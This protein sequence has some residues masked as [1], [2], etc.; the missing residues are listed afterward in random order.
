MR[1]LLLAVLILLTGSPLAHAAEGPL[2]T[3][4]WD[5]N[6]NGVRDEGEPGYRKA[7]IAIRHDSG[8]SA[9]VTAN[10]DGT[11]VLP[12]TGKWKISH[13]ET[14]YVTTTPTSV[15]SDGDD[16]EFGVRGAEVCGTV[17]RDI[18]LDAKI[19]E[20]EPG[21]EG[22]R[23]SVVGDPDHSTTTAADGTYCLHDLPT[24]TSRFQSQDRAAVDGTGWA[25]ADFGN[26]RVE[27]GSK[28]DMLTGQTREVTIDRPGS[29]IT[30]YDSG[31][32]DARGMNAKA[33]PITID[34][35]DYDGVRVGDRLI[36]RCKYTSG[37]TVPDS[38][39]AVL[40]LPEGLEITRAVG[41]RDFTAGTGDEVVVEG[42]KITVRSNG[43]VRRDEESEV[44]VH[45]EV[46]R[47]FAAQ[48]MTCAAP[49]SIYDPLPDEPSRFEI[50]AANADGSGPEA[51]RSA[52]FWQI[53]LAVVL[54]GAA[55][56]FV[57]RY[58]RRA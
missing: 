4:F 50:A 12:R 1:A 31:I 15:E 34:E 33:G 28:F 6:T 22:H 26:P 58:R 25:Y 7:E 45:A 14:R 39:G 9:V 13:E 32:A 10:D 3:V 51:T 47:A 19:T 11:Y 21:V 57:V 40:T 17:W 48:D 2:V 18:D 49:P 55:A 27:F 52:P 8:Y 30:G 53:A 56:L 54:V 23:I 36:L 29:V 38:R 20:K 41:Y 44:V 35:I 37:G 42:Q 43:R 46:R 5:R 24:G 16:V